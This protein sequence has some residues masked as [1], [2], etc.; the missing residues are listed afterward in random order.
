MLKYAR[1]TGKQQYRCILFFRH[2]HAHAP[3][4]VQLSSTQS[5]H[6]PPTNESSHAYTY[7]T[8]QHAYVACP[9]P[10]EAAL[11]VLR[12]PAANKKLAK[13]RWPCAS[14]ET[15]TISRLKCQPCQ[16]SRRS[17]RYLASF[18]TLRQRWPPSLCL[19]VGEPARY[20]LDRLLS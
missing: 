7:N 17:R 6:L 2:N 10:G 4:H 11:T 1:Q 3:N 9:P 20:R 14:T 15:K 5:R 12:L 19:R 18:P 16:L 13:R 8:T